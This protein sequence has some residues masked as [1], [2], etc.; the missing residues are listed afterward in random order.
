MVRGFFWLTLKNG[1]LTF[2]FNM[3]LDLVDMKARHAK[4]FRTTIPDF[5][6]QVT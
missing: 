5:G 3:V 2:L 1:L 4:H 6:N